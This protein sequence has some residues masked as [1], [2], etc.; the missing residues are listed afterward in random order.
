MKQIITLLL[1]VTVFTSCE[2]NIQDNTPAMQ[3]SINEEFFRANDSRGTLNEDGSF[4]IQGINGVETMTL[5]LREFR[6]TTYQ[7][8]G[9]SSNYATFEDKN[10][11]VY[12]TDPLGSGEIVLRSP[13]TVESGLAYGDFKF[14]AVRPGIDTIFVDK[15]FFFE[16][17]FGN[18][19]DDDDTVNAGSFVAD[20]DGVTFNPFTVSAVD[21]GNSIVILAST[22]NIN[23][24]IS[25]PNDVTPANYSL[26]MTGFTATYA[27]GTITESANSGTIIVLEHDTATNEI[28]GTFAFETDSK[29]IS[30]GQFNVVY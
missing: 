8:G 19:E 11:N 21:T 16:V 2:E 18:G 6:R 14:M 28:K 4:L 13:S 7:L 29:S 26:P 10:G 17:P 15:G 3:G 1:L 25:V 20:I 27:D 9:N 30:L 24:T 22:S 12:S 23:I 5:R